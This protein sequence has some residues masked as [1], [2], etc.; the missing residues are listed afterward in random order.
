VRPVARLSLVAV[1]LAVAVYGTASLTGGWLGTPPW[2]WREIGV[3]ASAATNGR[4]IAWVSLEVRPGREWISLGV[5][6]SG[7]VVASLGAW[8]RRWRPTATT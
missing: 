4:P 3:P 6:A 8:P 1:R 5:A 7:L 2:W